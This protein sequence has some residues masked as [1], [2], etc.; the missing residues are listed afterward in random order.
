[1]ADPLAQQPPDALLPKLVR[2]YQNIDGLPTNV[3]A[4]VA[5]MDLDR[6]R[7]GQSPLGKDDTAV[8][9]QAALR[10]KTTI[11]EPKQGGIGG[12]FGNFV[13]DLEG[14]AQ[15]IPHLPGALLNELQALPQG[16]GQFMEGLSQGDL[17]K[18]F[19]APGF[20]MLP[21]SYLL[22]QGPSAF[23]EHPLLAALDVAPYAKA[24]LGAGLGAID[25]A[26]GAEAG[27]TADLLKRPI[28]NTLDKFG[29][30]PMAMETSRTVAQANRRLSRAFNEHAAEVSGLLKGMS[31]EDVVRITEL[32]QKGDMTAIRSLPLEEQAKVDQ[33][34]AATQ[35]L[36]ER[37]QE[38][39]MLGQVDNEFYPIDQAER[40]QRQRTKFWNAASSGD[41]E[42]MKAAQQKF[43]KLNDKYVPG[44]FRPLL[45][46]QFRS[47]LADLAQSR[48]PDLHGEAWAGVQK[49]MEG[50]FYDMIPNVTEKDLS[51]LAKEITP[52]W[53]TM[54]A[55]GYDPVFIHSVGTDQMGKLRTP[56]VFAS[57]MFSPTS[58]KARTWNMA[59]SITNFAVGLNHQALEFMQY[60]ATNH[61]IAELR[62]TY[63]RTREDL[64]KEYLPIAEKLSGRA[65]V[66][67]Q[68][69]V[70]ALISKDYT[71]WNPE[72]VLSPWGK[73]RTP[74]M[75]GPPTDMYVPKHMASTVE[76]MYP[77][78]RS[79]LGRLWDTGMGVFRVGVL[80]LSPR[81]HLYNV[82]GGAMLMAGRTGPG[83]LKFANEARQM[84]ADGTMPEAISHG[85]VSVPEEMRAWATEDGAT[86]GKWLK[87]SWAKEAFQ[88]GV[89]PAQWFVKKS[90][91]FNGL[92][93][94]MY[95]TMSY[96]YGKDKA[97]TKG[98][99]ADA[100]EQAGVKLSNKVLQDWDAM[101][102]IE[103]QVIRS[104]FP[105]YGWA[106][107]IV[108]YVSTYPWDHPFRASVIGNLAR[109]E[110][111][112][113]K[114]GLPNQ[115][116]NY[117]FFGHP[118]EMGNQTGINVRGANP[119]ADVANYFT[120]AGFVSQMNPAMTGLMTA[121]G[122]NPRTGSA[123]LYPGLSYNPDTGRLEAATKNPLQTI[124]E[125]MVPQAAGLKSILGL[126]P[127]EL[128]T[129]ALNNPDAYRSRILSSFGLPPMPR[130]VNKGMELA[131]SEL[132][133]KKLLQ[134]TL[135]TAIRTGDYG[136]AE[137][138]KILTPIIDRLKALDKSGALD[139][140]KI[141]PAGAAQFDVKNLLTSIHAA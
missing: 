141:Q 28:V 52:Q 53:Q 24:G 98:M 91:A 81:W 20:R 107:H 125:G 93:D 25:A 18:A 30:G 89:K 54:K 6:A 40:L 102:P 8:A 9:L 19:S 88:K 31:D 116:H 120:L 66:N 37:G 5:Q 62:S 129:L 70:E 77:M 57:S 35:K 117:L 103:R 36:G 136:P 21:G 126:D 83:V 12:F 46:E 69:R 85:M 113:W 27:A 2:K 106:K 111:N 130:E 59:P 43:A 105:F 114:G 48:N 79:Q 34:R 73:A 23:V 38:L 97:L 115:F 3:I 100:A 14:A 4:P 108:G 80:P 60:E 44:R 137:Q 86:I 17:S 47:K 29:V 72:K 123:N 11:E 1:M 112:D 61:V 104:I 87:D 32:A 26:R 101:T 45:D 90:F 7:R 39:G 124:A 71:K 10:G 56:K 33:I 22:S 67:L 63:G 64:I 133:K 82:V 121:M 139:S 131:R 127:T 51:A 94:D 135:N 41:A 92:V 78:D 74:T 84:M 76:K 68:T 95:R 138:Y 109:N 122:F 110:M 50:R 99:T 134:D 65:G 42:G 15:S 140:L 55:A 119:F 118:D 16:P 75:G 132:A 96:L 49:L 58:V 128:K 13:N